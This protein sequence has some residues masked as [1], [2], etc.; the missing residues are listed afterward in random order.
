MRTIR[1]QT[2]LPTSAEN[3]WQAMQHAA[4]FLYVTRGL[5]GF[6]ALA[7]R[8]APFQ[9]GERGTGWLL[10]FHLIPLSRHTI[11][12]VEVDEATRTLRSRERGGVLKAWNHTLHVEPVDEQ[13][14]R[15]SDTVEIDAGRL[16][17]VVARVAVGIYRYRQRRWRKLVHQHLLP[18]GPRYGHRTAT[19]PTSAHM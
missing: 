6:P 8:T 16:T 1:V 14:C 15:Y 2:D 11:H 9:A 19:M 12:L 17:G 7:G 13:R 3:V 18:T 10:L 5:F 4:S